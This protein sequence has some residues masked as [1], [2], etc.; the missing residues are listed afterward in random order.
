MAEV[1]LAV[2]L[3]WE[4]GLVVILLTFTSYIIF[5]T[6][7]HSLAN[8]PG[9][10]PARYFGS[11]RNKRFWRGT[12]HEDILAAH[13]K[14]GRVVRIAPNQV[15]IVD[16]KAMKQLYGHGTTSVKT[17][18]YATW[19]PPMDNAESFFSE[20][21]RS[22]HAF[23]RKRVSGAYAMSAI[24]KYEDFIQVSLDKLL[25]KF[26]KYAGKQVDLS[27]WT[28]ALAFDVVG[29][30]GFGESL[31]HLEAEDDVM[32]LR[33]TIFDGFNM[34]S[35]MGYYY[36]GFNGY[37]WGQMRI[38]TNKVTMALMKMLGQKR[39]LE[40]FAPWGLERIQ[41]RLES[42]ARGEMGRDDMLAHFLRMKRADGSP[43]LLNE[44]LVEALMLVC[45]QFL[46]KVIFC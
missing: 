19:D 32:G 37:Y 17:Q 36:L 3:S 22:Y 7:F 43:A 30:L 27:E 6:Y 28:S 42:N 9:P 41:A 20:R 1:L 13:R 25:E 16:G 34:Q 24:L 10:W 35:C 14:Y 44:I 31:G 33:K 46:V 5:Q 26:K 39:P 8:I 21:N 12:W 23:L 2:G 4:T 18:W 29:Q 15:S 45:V 38:F 40:D 11:W